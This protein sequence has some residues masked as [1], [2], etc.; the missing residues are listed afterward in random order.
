MSIYA[1]LGVPEVWRLDERILTF[2]TL[3]ANRKYSAA[4]H[5]LSFPLV[6]P[7]DLMGFLAMCANQDENSVIRQFRTWIKQ[8]IA[9][10]GQTSTTP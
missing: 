7:A 8:R 4:S 5:S 3:G 10:G 2:Q 6:T 1:A 9:G